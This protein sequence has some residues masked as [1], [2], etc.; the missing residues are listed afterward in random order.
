MRGIVYTEFDSMVP[1]HGR[2]SKLAHKNFAAKQ[3]GERMSDKPIH[4]P[5]SFQLSR[6][7]ISS[8]PSA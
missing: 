2:Q 3:N 8:W 1:Q 6:Q 7:P 5:I 4:S